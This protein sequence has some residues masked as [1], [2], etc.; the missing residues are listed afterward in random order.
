[1]QVLIDLFRQQGAA[2]D[3]NAIRQV[4][5]DAF[6]ETEGATESFRET[7]GEPRKIQQVLEELV[8]QPGTV[9]RKILELGG[10]P[11]ALRGPWRTCS[12]QRT[13]ATN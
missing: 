1:M 10:D 5:I 3:P 9:R 12:R 11:S 4:L 6:L 8:W 2:R 13:L 7:G